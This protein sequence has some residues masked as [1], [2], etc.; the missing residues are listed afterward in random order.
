[1]ISVVIVEDHPLF[2]AAVDHVLR[3]RYGADV[4]VHSAARPRDLLSLGLG[5]EL[6]HAVVDL[7]FGPINIDAPEIR[8]EDESGVD[9]LLLLDDL[10]PDCRPVV[11]TS[12]DAA[13]VRE[14]AVAIRQTWPGVPFL[15]KQDPALSGR[16]LEFMSTGTV[17]DNVELDLL[18]GEVPPLAMANIIEAFDRSGSPGTIKRLVLHLA[19]LPEQPSRIAPV[20]EALGWSEQHV[21][22]TLGRL[23]GLLFGP[24]LPIFAGTG[25]EWWQWAR[26]RRGLLREGLTGHV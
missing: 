9:A 6:T 10:A 20:A 12:F 5:H 17:K 18:I 2:V 4:T 16:L 19:D 8:A 22:N 1:M 11:V 21:K 26:P 7:S 25:L 3:E 15:N 13:F 14:S 23:N 24:G